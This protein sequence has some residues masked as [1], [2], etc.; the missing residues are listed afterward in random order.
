MNNE[1]GAAY[2]LNHVNDQLIQ[3]TLETPRLDAV[4][5]YMIKRPDSKVSKRR[6]SKKWVLGYVFWE[7]YNINFFIFFSQPQ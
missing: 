5:P 7:F 2:F 4:S 6:N 1:G 3:Q